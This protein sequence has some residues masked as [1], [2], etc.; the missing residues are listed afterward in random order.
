MDE[1][2]NKQESAT[3]ASLD[4]LISRWKD[5]TFQEIIDDWK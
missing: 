2:K 5:G 3:F 1:N 4:I